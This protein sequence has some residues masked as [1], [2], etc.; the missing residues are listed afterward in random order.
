MA[1]AASAQEISFAE[2]RD[3]STLAIIAEALHTGSLPYADIAWADVNADGEDELFYFDDSQ[4][5]CLEHVC[6]TYLF[7]KK[8]DDWKVIFDHFTDTNIRL[9]N[10]ANEGYHSILITVTTD[11]H[12]Y[13]P[14]QRLIEWDGAY[15]Q[16]KW[17]KPIP[18]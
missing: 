2:T 9:L 5:T 10:D 13:Q 7:Q 12:I 3:A 6:V 14:H 11:L 16:Q 18:Y 17:V 8:P 15:Y 4:D 1:S